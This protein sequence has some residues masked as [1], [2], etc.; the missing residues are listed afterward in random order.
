MKQKIYRHL[1][2]VI[3]GSLVMSASVA[4]AG[5]EG[6]TYCQDEQVNQHWQDAVTKHKGDPLVMRLYA[7]RRGL[8]EMLAEKKVDAKAAR[9]MWDQAVISALVEK[10][11]EAA[12]SEA[13]LRLFGT[14]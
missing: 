8:C 2:A 13:L 4:Q 5:N 7:V 6:A 9:F 10:G 1:S 12:G 14:F 11:R 3:L